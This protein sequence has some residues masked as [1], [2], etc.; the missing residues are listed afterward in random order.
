MNITLS[1]DDQIV[2]Q[3]RKIA[4]DQNTTMTAIIRDFLQKM[5]ENEAHQHERKIALLE[6]NFECL[7]RDMGERQW[8][9][10]GLYER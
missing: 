4:F 10:D 5:V 8:N 9:R 6:K 2:K 7:E 3:A 1:V